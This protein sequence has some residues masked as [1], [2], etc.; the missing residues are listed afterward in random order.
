MGFVIRRPSVWKEAICS[1][2]DTILQRDGGIGSFCVRE[3]GEPLNAS[4][5][6]T[7]RKVIRENIYCVFYI[8][9]RGVC[10]LKMQNCTEAFET[11]Q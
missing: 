2:A 5:R 11:M 4:F 7:Q 6:C 9:H 3:T 8:L 10:Q 1:I